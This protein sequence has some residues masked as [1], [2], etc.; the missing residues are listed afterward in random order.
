MAL[1]IWTRDALRSET[2]P[3]AKTFWRCV[4]AQHVVSTLPLVDSLD[5]QTILEDILEKTKPSAPP[6]CDG[7]D[8]LYMTPFRYGLYPHGS[9]FR[10]AGPTPG[11]LYA[12]LAPETAVIETAFHLL[13]FY[14]DSPATPFPKDPTE[15]TLFDVVLDAKAAID[16][17]APPFLEA[18]ELWTSPTDYHDCQALE[19]AARKEGIDLI[20]YASVR[21][22][23]TRL[24]GALLTCA[25]FGAT[26]PT[27][28]RSWKLWFNA[29]GVHAI[30]EF[31]A[32]R[33][34]LAIGV[35][36][37]DPRLAAMAWD[38]PAKNS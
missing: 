29:Q 12:S 19:E 17:T 1:P 16:L 5:E 25:A 14:A 37:A 21:D 33:I 6:E 11:V 9:R 22:P 4:E 3:Y 31:G 13:L 26:G 15:Q 7:L 35:F 27:Q 24:N 36:A 10:K 28:H 34:S 38:R 32:G 18:A 8:Y 30:E 23:E 20:L 2:A